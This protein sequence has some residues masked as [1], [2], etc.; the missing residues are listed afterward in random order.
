MC[1]TEEARRERKWGP[2]PAL[3]KALEDKEI[4]GN[5]Y[6][7]TSAHDNM[8]EAMGRLINIAVLVEEYESDIKETATLVGREEMS[9]DLHE[10][11][12]ALK[13]ASYFFRSAAGRVQNLHRNLYDTL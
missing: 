7:I 2:F 9:R 10:L 4:P 5:Y 13:G 12:D 3:R 1:L 8:F 11:E 6:G